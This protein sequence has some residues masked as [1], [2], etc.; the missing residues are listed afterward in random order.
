MTP[1]TVEKKRGGQRK[2]WAEEARV[3]V[4]YCYVKGRCGWSD[5]VLDYEFAW[6]EEG[7]A[8]RSK[9][10]DRPR[11]FE[12]IR[13]CA[14]KP[15][16]RDPRW[17]DI[18]ELVLAVDQDPIFNG[19]RAVYMSKF[20]DLLQEQR[21][22]ISSVKLEVEQILETNRLVRI[23]TRKSEFFTKLIDKYGQ[24][25]VFD[26]CLELSLNQVDELSGMVLTWLVY[27]QTEPIHNMHVRKVIESIADNQLDLFFK[28]YYPNFDYLNNY[29]KAIDALLNLKLDMS[30]P[31]MGGYGFLEIYGVWPIIPLN[32]ITSISEKDLF[33]INLKP[34][35]F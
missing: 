27:L 35:I 9:D 26:R 12:W 7:K 11:T 34:L 14:R 31:N 4:W 30:E 15:A 19:T 2:H 20:W 29:S 23:D 8:S 6:T 17:R 25:C 21:L 1:K 33:S 32:V 16:G 24:E 28:S 3:W 13:K 5:Y 18:N 10:D 22:T